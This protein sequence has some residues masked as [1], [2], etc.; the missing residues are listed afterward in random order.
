[1]KTKLL[2]LTT[3]LSIVFSFANVI[4]DINNTNSIKT[5]FF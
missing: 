1:M 3:T 4:K 5:E 2:F